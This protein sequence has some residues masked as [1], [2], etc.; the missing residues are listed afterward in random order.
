MR[1]IFW[2]VVLG[3]FLLIIGVAALLQTLRMVNFNSGFW[4]VFMAALFVLAG[5]AFLVAL[6]QTRA[7][8]WAAIPGVTLVSIGA[9]IGLN[10]LAPGFAPYGGPLVLGGIGLSFW[11]VYL[12]APQNWWAIIPGGVMVSLAVVAGVDAVHVHSIDSG[13][14]LFLGLAVTFALLGILPTGG[15]RMTWPWIPAAVLLALG[16]LVSFSAAGFANFV[17]PVVLILLG[18]F[19]LTRNMIRKSQ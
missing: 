2:R 4:P 12:V 19:F 6:F 8:W 18:V 11:L 16:V 1:P 17:W 5:L 3:V 14:Y 13:G 9:L 10:E 7:N 15:R